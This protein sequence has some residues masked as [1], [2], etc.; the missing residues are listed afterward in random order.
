MK[1]TMNRETNNRNTQTQQGVRNTN[2][3]IGTHGKTIS[4]DD[5]RTIKIMKHQSEINNGNKSTNEQNQCKRIQK[6]TNGSNERENKSEHESE[7]ESKTK[8][9][10]QS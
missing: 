10:N 3:K 8:T 6:S 2:V 5:M 4:N 7:H 9:E 1:K